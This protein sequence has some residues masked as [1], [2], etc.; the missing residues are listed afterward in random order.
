M[1]ARLSVALLAAW[2]LLGLYGSWAYGHDYWG[3]RGFPP[4]VDPPGVAAGR[5]V[6]NVGLY[7]PSLRQPRSYDIYLPPRYAQQ[8]RAGRRFRVLYLLHGAPGTAKTFLTAGHLGVD[9]D[10]LIARHAVAP[11]LVVF[12][13]GGDGTLTSDTEWADTPHGKYESFV[14]DVV[15]A[16]DARWATIP[17]RSARAIAGNSEGAYGAVNIALHHLDTFSL[18]QSW[19]GYFLQTRSGVFEHATPA[20]LAAASP[21]LS[22][23]TLRRAFARRPFHVVLY[24]GRQDPDTRQLAPFAAALR[25]AGAQVTTAT[26]PGRHDWR[27][28]RNETPAMLRNVD[29]T[30]QL[31]DAPDG[32][33]QPRTEPLRTARR[34]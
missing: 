18:A 10:T 5:L 31:S 14:L 25:A 21:Q 33:A 11:F 34:R 30:L 7:S 27:L 20:A 19:S 9:L 22:V 13:H 12:P 29:A 32:R 6:K 16:V 1:R 28:W 23:H 4:P 8:A 2:L 15:H 17:D 26:P 3:N 24:G